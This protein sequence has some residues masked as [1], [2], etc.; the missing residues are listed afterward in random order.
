[1][2][3]A[4]AS[5]RGVVLSKMDEAV[6]LGPALDAMIRHKLKVLARGQRPARARGLAPPVGP[7]AGAARA[8]QRRQPG[9]AL[10]ASDV[11]LVFAGLP[12][13]RPPRAAPHA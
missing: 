11:N 12:R 6:K 7:R 3:T 13:R 4:R 5:C 8:A 2:P 10:D 9:L 1:M